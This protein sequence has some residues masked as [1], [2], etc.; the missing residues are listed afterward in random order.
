VPDRGERRLVDDRRRES[1]FVPEALLADEHGSQH[2]RDRRD[3]DDRSPLRKRLLGADVAPPVRNTCWRVISNADH[4]RLPG[5]VELPVAVP[6]GAAL[7]R[8]ESLSGALAAR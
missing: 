7:L 5:H 6:D 1:L 8:S 4:S 2:D 3:R